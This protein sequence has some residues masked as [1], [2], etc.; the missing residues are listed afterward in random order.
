M[1]RCGSGRASLPGP[2]RS[3]G[4]TLI[5]LLIAVAVLG[6]LASVAVVNYLGYVEKARIARAVAEIE[7]IGRVIDAST[8]EDGSAL[9]DSL[10]GAEAEHML[11]PW[12]RPYRYLKIA[13]ALPGGSASPPGPPPV[14]AAPQDEG[15]V[16]AQARKDQFLV[17]I[18]S[19][20]D[21]YSLGPDGETL[22]VLAAPVSRDDV[23]RARD[24]AYVGLAEA[25]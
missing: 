9:P 25:F 17:P 19:D 12:G 2:R 21:L 22:P 7:S 23:I 5:E 8:V 15:T 18:N 10:A 13:G 1:G 11:D 6:A 16:L 20:Y 24:G 3:V 14:S 4:Y